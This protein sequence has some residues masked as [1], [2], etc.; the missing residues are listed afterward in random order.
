MATNTSEGTKTGVL[1]AG[2]VTAI[3]DAKGDWN[4]RT[5]DKRANLRGDVKEVAMEVPVVGKMIVH[6]LGTH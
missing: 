4:T 1:E 6:H 2:R 5:N 3:G